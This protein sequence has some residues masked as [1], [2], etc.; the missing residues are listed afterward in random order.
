[1]LNLP[2]G[3]PLLVA[4]GMTFESEGGLGRVGLTQAG[5]GTT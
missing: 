1:M 4:R 5:F 3:L 2:S